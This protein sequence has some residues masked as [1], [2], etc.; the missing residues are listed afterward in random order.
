MFAVLYK[1]GL[2]H[3]VGADA[4]SDFFKL[5]RIGTPVGISPSALRTQLSQMEA[6]ILTFQDSCEQS[7]P[8]QTRKAVL[9]ADETFFGE[10]LILVLMDLSSGYLLL[11][12]IQDDRRFDTWLAQATPRLDALG[13][14][15][16]HAVSDRAKALIKLAIEGFDC[17][18]G[19]DVF[20]EQYGLSRWLGSALGRRKVKADKHGDAAQKAV[21]KAS[22]NDQAALKAQHVQAIERRTQ[23]DK[24][25]QEY[26]ENLLGITDDLHPFSLEDNTHNTVASITLKLEKRAKLLDAIAVQQ[27]IPDK[28]NALRKFR[29]Q[30]GALASPVSFWWFWVEEILLDW[31]VDEATRQWLTGILL[32]LVYWHYPLH[33]TK[34]PGQRKRYREAWQRAL[35]DFNADP[36][37]AGLSE[38]DQQRWLAWAEWMVRQFHRSSSAVEGR[39]GRLSQLYHNGRGVTE[40]SL[41]ASTVIHNYGIK[42]SDGTTAAER[43]YGTAF[44]DLFGWLV[45][46]MDEIPLPRKARQRV[47]RNSLKF[48][49]VPA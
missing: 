12:S 27:D 5:I 43:F 26:H 14:K 35:N 23:V 15:V 18:S 40:S 9:A 8:A 38:C 46:H 25:K 41:K 3:A 44:P 48:Q 34:K 42:R 36:F 19:A 30:I 17:D 32:P 1:F 4:V 2:Q 21:N 45:K 6:L 24:A 13:I 31:S 28:H 20:H 29:G 7:A 33:K 16:G 37:H 22:V 47:I 11:E 39:N 49:N 10:R